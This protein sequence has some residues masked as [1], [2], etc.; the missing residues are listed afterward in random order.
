MIPKGHVAGV[1]IRRIVES[2]QLY[3]MG[4]ESF[5]PSN[6]PSR[7]FK[8]SDFASLA[9]E[10]ILREQAMEILK[11]ALRGVP[12]HS[13]SELIAR[14][15]HN[16]LASYYEAL[17]NG[18]T[19]VA[20]WFT[21][22]PTF[23]SFIGDI[24]YLSVTSNERQLSLNWTSRVSDRIAEALLTEA[25]LL[26]IQRILDGVCL[27]API[28]IHVTLKN[29]VTTRH[30]EHLS[31]LFRCPVKTAKSTDTLVY[32]ISLIEAP[33]HTSIR[34]AI[35]SASLPTFLAT[36]S[37]HPLDNFELQMR[38]LILRYLEIDGAKL[39]S[40]AANLAMSPR[41]LQR[42]L[43]TAN[44]NFRELRSSLQAERASRHLTN[45]RLP[46][47]KIAK[48][49][50]FDS[51]SAFTYAFKKQFGLTPKQFRDRRL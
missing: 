49:T 12:P 39:G 2:A 34:P 13:R 42:K 43:E 5:T 19:T 25:V 27:R 33:L 22:V 8:T 41:T 16:E 3:S 11:T 4:L 38:V 47:S 7:M 26:C 31:K 20:D 37:D 18:V 24:G 15:V 29:K 36:V 6:H 46:I 23:E 17:T 35:L 30:Q 51:Q 50:G 21:R 1:H 14:A 45:T 44:I 28:P 9:A 48:I 40:I 32:N 10:F